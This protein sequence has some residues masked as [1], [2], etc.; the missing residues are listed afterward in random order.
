M[1]VPIEKV[2]RIA[3][4]HGICGPCEL[5]A[6]SGMVNE[7]WM[8][9]DRY[10]LRITVI[11]EAADEA[12]REA[13][14][15][16]V[17]RAAGVRSPELI[18]ADSSRTLI[19]FPFTIYERAAG[20]LL[21]HLKDD[22]KEFMAAYRE[23]GREMA[24]LHKIEIPEEKRHGLHDSFTY[25]TD[26]QIAK[27]LDAGKITSEEA[28]ETEK[29]IARLDGMI[30]K[31]D[32]RAF[33]HQDIH[34]WNMF[35]DPNIKQLTAIIDWGDAAWGDPAGEFSS[36]P[37]VAVPEMFAGYEEAG[38]NIDDGMRARALMFGLGLS[39]WELRELDADRFDRRW[40]RHP[41][42]G[43]SETF[44]IIEEILGV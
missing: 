11:E 16:P 25:D 38:G 39:M 9:D 14:V 26:K 10:V 3:V 15:V 7:A 1:P 40:W 13:W 43:L 29:W 12:T 36:M 37:L 19:E 27:T 30:D 42:G 41:P 34:P 2:E 31:R 6:A 4:A 21:G 5:M 17:V 23:V 22:P 44:A 28:R 24:Q 20:E 33:L 32:R 8:L 35:V 18:V